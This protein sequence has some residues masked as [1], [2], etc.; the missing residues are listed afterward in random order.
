MRRLLVVTMIL[1]ATM[2]PAAAPAG[3]PNWTAWLEE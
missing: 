2:L 1:M 3:Q